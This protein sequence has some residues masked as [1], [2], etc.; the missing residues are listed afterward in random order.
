MK[1]GQT[2]RVLVGGGAG[3]KELE[4]EEAAAVNTEVNGY[5]DESSRACSHC[6]CVQEWQ[7]ERGG[8]EVGAAWSY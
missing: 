3:V 2:S 4:A 7:G 5:P 6:H 1:W 8:R